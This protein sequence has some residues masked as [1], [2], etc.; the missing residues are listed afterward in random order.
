VDFGTGLLYAAYSGLDTFLLKLSPTGQTIWAKNFITDADDRGIDVSTDTN[1]NILLTGYHQGSINFGGGSMVVNGGSDV[2]VAKFSTLGEH[3][4]SKHFGGIYA[5]RGVGISTDSNGNVFIFGAFTTSIDFGG[6]SIND[7][8][9]GG[10]DAFLV[11]LSSNGTHIWSKALNSPGSYDQPNA[12]SIDFNGNVIIVGNFRISINL[13]GDVLNVITTGIQDFYIAKYSPSGIHQWSKRFGGNVGV[14]A[15]GVTTDSTGYVY[16][17]GYFQGV[18]DFN[19]K[20][21]SSG[22]SSDLYLFKLEP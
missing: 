22:G 3:I 4:W 8:Y 17:T 6:G 15:L 21:L 14:D 13:G 11:K 7:S 1:G 18:V 12:M 2:Y 10:G 16:T 9:G 19:N 5:D 20:S